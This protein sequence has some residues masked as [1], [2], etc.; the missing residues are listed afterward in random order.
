MRN[1][2][3]AL[4]FL[5]SACSTDFAVTTDWKDVTVVYG[6]LDA[7]D[8]AQY[9]KIN[10]AF[11]DPQTNALQLAQNPDSLYYPYLDVV[12]EEISNGQ[13]VKTVP[14]NRVDGNLEGYVKDSGIFASSPNY[15]YKTTE[16]LNAASSYRLVITQPDNGKQTTSTSPVVDD[17]SVIRPTPQLKLNLLPGFKYNISWVSARDG[18]VYALTFR[19]YYTEFRFSDPSFVEQKFAD[20]VLFTSERAPNT[21]GG[22]NMDFD[23]DAD[24]FYSWLRSA[25]PENPDIYRQVGKADFLFSVGGEVLD[26]YKQVFLAQQGLTSGQSLPTYTNIENGLGLFSTRYHKTVAG[27]SFENRTID[28]IA[29]LPQTRQ[30]NFLRSNGTL[31]P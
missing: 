23:L 2:P 12:L 30:L 8:T 17:F 31:C 11:L 7:G 15:L 6:L 24:L 18:K 5:F 4:L 16:K 19:F 25:L 27:I 21:S 1:A 22:V 20:W 26:T 29:C 28:S 13:T 14:L 9:I 10:K 3:I